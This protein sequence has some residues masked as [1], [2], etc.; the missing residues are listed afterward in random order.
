MQTHCQFTLI[1]NKNVR[2]K[3]KLIFEVNEFLILKSLLV[4][5]CN[6]LLGIHLRISFEILPGTSEEFLTAFF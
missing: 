6:I 5:L 3:H 2:N 1:A 4:F